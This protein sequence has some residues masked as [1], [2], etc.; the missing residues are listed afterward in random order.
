MATA[1]RAANRRE[2][3]GALRIFAV[4]D[5]DGRRGRCGARLWRQPRDQRR[6]ASATPREMR[7][8]TLALLRLHQPLTPVAGMTRGIGSPTKQTER[9]RHGRHHAVFVISSVNRPFGSITVYCAFTSLGIV[10]L[11]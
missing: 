11:A 5:T 9:I 6:Q 1:A 4:L 2:H 8:S 10:S 7:R 3:Q